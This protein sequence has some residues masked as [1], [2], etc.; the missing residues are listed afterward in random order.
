MQLASK[1][2]C[3]NILFYI[4]ISAEFSFLSFLSIIFDF[5]LNLLSSIISMTQTFVWLQIAKQYFVSLAFSIDF[6]HISYFI[7]IF[8]P[9]KAQLSE[10]WDSFKCGRCPSLFLFSLFSSGSL[11][12]LCCR[13]WKTAVTLDSDVLF[14]LLYM[15]LQLSYLCKSPKT[16]SVFLFLIFSGFLSHMICIPAHG[17]QRERGTAKFA[18]GCLLFMMIQMLFFAI[19]KIKPVLW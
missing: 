11:W 13:P 7:F 5:C 18:E 19:C 4:H 12:L 6:S 2:K 3:K 9:R 1:Q 15:P 17:L 16:L 14:L 10:L 8:F